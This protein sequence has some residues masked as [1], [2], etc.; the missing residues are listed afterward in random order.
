[1]LILARTKLGRDATLLRHPVTRACYH[2]FNFVHGY[3]YPLP[4]PQNP[5]IVTVTFAATNHFILY[6]PLLDSR[7]LASILQIMLD[8]KCESLICNRLSLNIILQK[9]RN[10][11]MTAVEPGAVEYIKSG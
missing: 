6:Y 7:N 4:K 11:S 2:Y 3:R 10:R 1:M 8:S 9:L 5:V